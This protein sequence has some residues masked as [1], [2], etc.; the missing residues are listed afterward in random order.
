MSLVCCMP[1]YALISS[2]KSENLHG[3]HSGA[4]LTAAPTDGRPGMNA[5]LCSRFYTPEQTTDGVWLRDFQ[6]AAQRLWPVLHQHMV[7]VLPKAR[8]ISAAL[9]H[10]RLMSASRRYHQFVTHAFDECAVCPCLLPVAN[11]H[12]NAALLESSALTTKAFKEISL[13]LIVILRKYV[14]QLSER[15]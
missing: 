6:A 4:K 15:S 14:Q 8:L 11:A 3:T 10:S 9:Q 7:G 12:A 5:I 13:A 1:W 2:Q